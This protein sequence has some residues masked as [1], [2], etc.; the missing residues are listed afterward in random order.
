M[1]S[2]RWFLLALGLLVATT[3]YAGG[4]REEAPDTSAPQVE[5][6]VYSKAE[7]SADVDINDNQVIDRIRTETGVDA[8]WSFLPED[9]TAERLAVMFASGDAPDIIELD[10]KTQVAR[11]ATQGVLA[12]LND[13][14]ESHGTYLLENIP[15]QDWAAVTSEGNIY[16]IPRPANYTTTPRA[17]VVRKDWL[18][19][20]GLDVPRTPQEFLE[21]LRVFRDED[22]AG[23]GNTVPLAAAQTIQGMEGLAAAFGIVVPYAER[24][25]EVVY[26][27]VEPEAR[28]FLEFA[29]Q[30]Y[31]EGLINED[32]PV[33]DSLDP[34]GDLFASGFAGMTTMYWWDA[35]WLWPSLLENDPDAEL[36][37]IAPAVSDTGLTG[38]AARPPS[39][40]MYVFPASTDNL[41]EAVGLV[42][43]IAANRD[44]QFYITYGE[45]G[46]HHS[47]D[48]NGVITPNDN[49]AELSFAPNY[50][51][52][53]SYENF[54]NRVR[55][56]GFFPYF[57]VMEEYPVV[58]NAYEYV[59]PL[60][61]VDEVAAE[62]EDL[63]IE[64]YV[65]I[66]TGAIPLESGWQDYVAAWRATGGEEAL[67]AIQAAY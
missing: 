45:E 52:W 14:L 21:V 16:A 33:I 7:V 1:K 27:S 40:Q 59:P 13:A 48:G 28:E 5:V 25:G 37:Y 15:A 53:D 58:A 41:E 42:N 22:P 60:P 10:D 61:E 17:M 55:Y 23:G 47:V 44:L 34:L 4:N 54:M 2:R 38:H 63:R 49:I 46:T 9:S 43:D 51:L 8:V 62:L 26:T 67:A 64:Y 66:I 57:S 19:R 20:Y 30:L 18:D 6:M 65:K 12:P 50:V 56:R 3:T 35:S 24:D 29:R 39:E 31:A 36:I 11:Y 32:Y